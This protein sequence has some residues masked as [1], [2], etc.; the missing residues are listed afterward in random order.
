MKKKETNSFKVTVIIRY[1]VLGK[2][3]TSEMTVIFEFCSQTLCPRGQ[4]M[5]VED[6]CTESSPQTPSSAPDDDWVSSPD[7]APDDSTIQVVCD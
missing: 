7:H 6:H 2:I 5:E 4:R 3:C 1:F